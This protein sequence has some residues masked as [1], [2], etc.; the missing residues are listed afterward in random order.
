MTTR[1]RTISFSNTV[2][3]QLGVTFAAHAALLDSGGNLDSLFSRAFSR[4]FRSLCFVL[5]FLNVNR[6]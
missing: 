5:S 2:F 4:V 1:G 6:W 3:S